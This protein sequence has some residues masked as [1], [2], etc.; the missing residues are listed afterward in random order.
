VGIGY[1]INN[2]G[3]K[4]MNDKKKIDNLHAELDD[5]LEMYNRLLVENQTQREN[6]KYLDDKVTKMQIEINEL[7]RYKFTVERVIV[8]LKPF[9]RIDTAY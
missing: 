1:A 7:N 3:Y 6:V 5:Q 8:S 2:R 9:L 4:N